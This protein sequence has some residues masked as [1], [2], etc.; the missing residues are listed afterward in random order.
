MDKASLFSQRELRVN[1]SDMGRASGRE[2]VE[3][4]A[5][6]GIVVKDSGYFRP[7]DVVTRAELIAM[8]VRCF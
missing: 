7:D 3:L 2:A 1:S 8:L 6:A 5:A 4:L